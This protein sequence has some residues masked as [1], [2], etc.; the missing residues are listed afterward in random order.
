VISILLSVIR[1][2][3]P[4]SSGGFEPGEIDRVLNAGCFQYCA[5][6]DRGCWDA[7]NLCYH[8]MEVGVCGNDTELKVLEY[9]VPGYTERV[10]TPAEH[11]RRYLAGA[12][13]CRLRRSG[14]SLD[15]AICGRPWE[16]AVQWLLSLSPMYWRGGAR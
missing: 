4:I 12:C 15:M 2:S 16:W 1:L 5:R 7:I 10:V 13:T 14:C 3:V 8:E 11:D 9:F 6:E